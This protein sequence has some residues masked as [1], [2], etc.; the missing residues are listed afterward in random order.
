MAYER[1]TYDVWR[2]MCDY[3]YGEGYENVYESED[4]ADAKARYEEYKREDIYAISVKLV[5]RRVPKYSKLLAP[6]YGKVKL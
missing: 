2:V 3:G 4:R 1:K 6:V 5:K